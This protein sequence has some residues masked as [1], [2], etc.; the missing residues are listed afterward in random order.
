MGKKKLDKIGCLAMYRKYKV[1]IEILAHP[2]DFIEFPIDSPA[3]RKIYLRQV[4]I[5]EK[6]CE[7]FPIME[8]RN[9]SLGCRVLVDMLPRVGDILPRVVVWSVCVYSH[10]WVGKF[11]EISA[12]L[13]Y[14]KIR[15]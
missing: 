5:Q 15:G 12:A 14:S 8:V 6:N 13:S 9:T 2:F 4:W 10:G 11:S 1:I 7:C 3:P